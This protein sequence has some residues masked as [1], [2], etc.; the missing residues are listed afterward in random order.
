MFLPR[1]PSPQ[2]IKQFLE[3]SQSLPLSYEP[4]GIA[5]ESPPGFKIDEASSVIGQG[6]ESFARAK[7]ALT[8]WKQFDLGWVELHPQDAP[9]EVGTV[10]SRAGAPSRILVTQWLSSCLSAG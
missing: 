3:R 10:V 9:I 8:S 2:T 5:K 4:I 6:V 1:R 7:Q